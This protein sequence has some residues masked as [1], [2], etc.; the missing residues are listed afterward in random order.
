MS[1]LAIQAAFIA[2]S[3]RLVGSTFR[4]LETLSPRL[5]ATRAISDPPTVLVR[6]LVTISMAWGFAFLTHQA[7]KPFAQRRQW[8]TTAVQFWTAVIGTALAESCGRFIAYRKS[9]QPK[10]LRQTP[11]SASRAL[12]MATLSQIPVSP[13]LTANN[14]VFAALS[15]TTT[16]RAFVPYGPRF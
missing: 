2:I 15:N 5:Q 4:V 6:E 8:G 9:H 12:P 16:N 10:R 13:S 14:T 1:S 3:S 11:P 7:I